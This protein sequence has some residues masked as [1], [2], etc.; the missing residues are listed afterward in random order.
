MHNAYW[1][2]GISL[3]IEHLFRIVVNIRCALDS[4]GLDSVW[5]GKLDFPTTVA[6]CCI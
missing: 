6:F 5:T 2:N 1:H 3:V 4:M